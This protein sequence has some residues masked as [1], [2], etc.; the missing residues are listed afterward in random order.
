MESWKKEESHDNRTAVDRARPRM[1]K[2][3]PSRYGELRDGKKN[4]GFIVCF[5]SRSICGRTGGLYRK[6]WKRGFLGRCKASRENFGSQSA[7]YDPRRSG[8]PGKCAS[9]EAARLCQQRERFLR[10]AICYRCR[11]RFIG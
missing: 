1:A 11:F 7:E 10:S 3:T 4:G 8:E 5:R 6:G 9:G 2:V